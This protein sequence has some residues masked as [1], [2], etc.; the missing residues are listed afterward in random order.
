MK[1]TAWMMCAG[2]F[3]AAGLLA[4]CGNGVDET[5]TPAQIK[6]EIAGW[7]AE[8][9]QKTADAYRNAVDARKAELDAV[10]GKIKQLSPQELLG[11]KGLKLKQEADKLGASLGK[12]KDN[13]AAYLDGLKSKATAK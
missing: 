6:Q 1:R 9:L 7:S 13:M 8:R 12:L 10:L 5:K 4:G 11:E 2:A 3:F